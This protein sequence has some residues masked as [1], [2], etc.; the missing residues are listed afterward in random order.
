MELN[1]LTIS[2]VRKITRLS[3]DGVRRAIKSGKLIAFKVGNKYLIA[4]QDLKKFIENN[5]NNS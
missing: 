2:E 1:Y 5:N 3:Y 4:P